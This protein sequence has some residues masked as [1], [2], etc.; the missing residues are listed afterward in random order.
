VGLSSVLI[1]YL[2]VQPPND[3]AL[4]I[5]LAFLVLTAVVWFGFERRRF[6]G[7]PTANMKT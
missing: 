3:A 5:T 7:P 1:L 4:N 6:Q 2:G